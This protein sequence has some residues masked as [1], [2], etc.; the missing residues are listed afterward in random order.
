MSVAAGE[1]P[2]GTGVAML[3]EFFNLDPVAAERL[4]GEIGD[5]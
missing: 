4:M 2:R 5:P 1:L 3:V